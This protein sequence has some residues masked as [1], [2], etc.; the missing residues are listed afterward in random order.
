VPFLISGRTL[1]RFHPKI[2]NFC[3]EKELTKLWIFP[4]KANKVKRKVSLSVFHTQ[5]DNG[6]PTPPFHLP[7]GNPRLA[8]HPN[9][10]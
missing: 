6:T 4:K 1:V 10:F 9:C 7:M 3:T 8:S 2:L 5:Q